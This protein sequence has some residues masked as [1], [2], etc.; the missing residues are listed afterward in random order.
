MVGVRALTGPSGMRSTPMAHEIETAGVT[1]FGS[2]RH[3]AGR[4]LGAVWPAGPRRQDERWALDILLDG[5]RELWHR[6]SGPDRRHAVRVAREATRLLDEAGLPARREILAAALLHDV[7]KVDCGLGTLSRV[8]VTFEAVVLGTDRFGEGAR[9]SA[10]RASARR[11]LEHDRIGAELL[12][13]AGSDELTI[14]WAAQHHLAP[15][16][17]TIEPEVGRLLKAADGG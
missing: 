4:W 15:G 13:S 6:M 17:W 5:E 8:R 10:R 7:G 12:R 16:A 3:L 11:Y 1:R 9:D 14:A 2:L